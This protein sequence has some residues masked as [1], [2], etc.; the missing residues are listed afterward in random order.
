MQYQRLWHRYWE[1]RSNAIYDYQDETRL[2]ASE[3]RRVRAST[4]LDLGCGTAPHARRL[5]ELG[6]RLTSVDRD[7]RLLREANRRAR[8]SSGY[9]RFLKADIRNLPTLA[10]HDAAF[11][12]H[13]TFPKSDWS[14]ILKGLRK[15]LKVGGIFIAGFLY[16]DDRI[17]MGS[18]GVQADVLR[19]PTGKT[20]IEVDH[21]I[22]N[23]D[24]FL[25][26]MS[27][28]EGPGA[29][30]RHGSHITRIYY[31]AERILIDSFLGDNGFVG[32]R[33][34]TQGRIGIGCLTAVLLSMVAE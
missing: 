10:P 24:H 33:Q 8:I 5:A 7:S 19:L 32:I 6:F 2:L 1:E 11:A 26:T 28:I 9:I 22:V 4:V 12:M 20:L 30:G 25:C 23:Q 31:F 21:H 15:A 29:T 18:E 17:E 13:L 34:I 14:T 16:P 3:L 27:L